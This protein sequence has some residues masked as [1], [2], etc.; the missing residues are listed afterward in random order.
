MTAVGYLRG[1]RAEVIVCRGS[2][3]SYPRHNHVSMLTLGLV[4]EGAV[5]LTTDRGAGLYREN[6]LFALLPY[7]PHSLSARAPYTL[8]SLCVPKELAVPGNLEEAQEAAASL[9]RRTLG[10]PEAERRLLEGLSGLILAGEGAPGNSGGPL[11]SLRAR[12]EIEPELPC[13][14][15]DM[16]ALAR[17]SKYHLVRAF[18]REAGLTPHQFQLQNRVRK[19]Q[20][21]LDGP[22]TVAE[23]AAAAGFCD[24]SHF[25]RHFKRLVGL[26]PA[27][28]KR[29]CGALPSLKE[30]PG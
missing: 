29:S 12:L 17:M 27:D 4:L 10:R 23:A 20:R 6:G 16:A 11:E 15:E 30:G 1:D 18:R 24:Q 25:D 22:A 3:L 28:Y 14:L 13:S 2:A 8:V 5:E 19:G 7:A 21:L 9:L 26:T